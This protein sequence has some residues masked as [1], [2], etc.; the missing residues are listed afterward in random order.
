MHIFEVKPEFREKYNLPSHQRQFAIACATT[1][2]KKANEIA[3]SL[4]LANNTFRPSYTYILE[5]H[6]L[7]PICE[8]EG[9]FI[10]QTGNSDAY[11]SIREA[12]RA[13]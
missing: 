7:L 8:K 6:R 12:L 13:N 10:V 5:N 2:L 3:Q 11:V 9:G 4:G 1:S